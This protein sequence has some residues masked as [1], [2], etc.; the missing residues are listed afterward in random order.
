M[1]RAVREH[2][3]KFGLMLTSVLLIAIA[4]LKLVDGVV[5]KRGELSAI[6]GIMLAIIAIA[7]IYGVASVDLAI[8]NGL[9]LVYGLLCVFSLIFFI[10][11]V[12]VQRGALFTLR[13]LP[14]MIGV[15]LTVLILAVQTL[16]IKL[17]MRLHRIVDI[18]VVVEVT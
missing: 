8:L 11:T 1:F 9:M 18:F 7:T 13:G 15:T 4:I 17:F 3:L 16:L 14:N 2:Q 5:T 12:C 6:A 10:V